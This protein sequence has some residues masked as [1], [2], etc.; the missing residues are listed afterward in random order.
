MRA[1]LQAQTRQKV[2]SLMSELM[3]DRKAGDD[4]MEVHLFGTTKESKDYKNLY[5][6]FVRPR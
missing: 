2:P 1:P 4:T 3:W 6:F 5:I